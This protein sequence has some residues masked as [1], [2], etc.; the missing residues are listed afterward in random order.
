MPTPKASKPVRIE[1]DLYDA[2]SAAAE[3]MSR[4]T[5]QQITHWARIGRE[6]EASSE[7]SIPE[8]M[9]VLRK[10]ASYD[11]LGEREQALVRAYW[12]SRMETLRSQLRLDEDFA[13]QGRPYAELDD[14]GRVVRREPE[15][16][17]SAANERP[18]RPLNHG[19]SDLYFFGVGG[20]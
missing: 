2:A 4:S 3:V 16:R 18:E 12:A 5:T 14:E 10:E 6:I 11:D 8:V 13:A 20:G 1:T 17:P 9:D 15:R 7:V 19:P